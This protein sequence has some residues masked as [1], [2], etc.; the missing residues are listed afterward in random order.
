MLCCATRE[1]W[2]ITMKRDA[3]LASVIFRESLVRDQRRRSGRRNDAEKFQVFF[4]FL[5]KNRSKHSIEGEYFSAARHY[6]C[7][8]RK[9]SDTNPVKIMNGPTVER[10]VR[11]K[12]RKERRK[13]PRRAS[14]KLRRIDVLAQPKS[15]S[16]RKRSPS[17]PRAAQNVRK[18]RLS[19]TKGGKSVK[20]LKTGEKTKKP[21]TITLS[22]KLQRRLFSLVYKR[23][24]ELAKSGKI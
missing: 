24:K 9:A 19:T 10:T 3:L 4:F 11:E 5:L 2:W 14:K 7:A 17:A 6:W 18:P 23:I 21:A 13:K 15:Q 12:P 16:Q 20:T 22:K 8:P 1:R